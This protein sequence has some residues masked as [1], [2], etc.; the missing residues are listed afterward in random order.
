MFSVPATLATIAI[1]LQQ[2]GPFFNIMSRYS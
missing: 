1:G 2:Y